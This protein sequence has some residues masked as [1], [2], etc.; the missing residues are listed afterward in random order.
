MNFENYCNSISKQSQPAS[1]TRFDHCYVYMKT[2]TRSQMYYTLIV[3]PLNWFQ[4]D[5]GV[6]YL[7]NI[8]KDFKMTAVVYTFQI[9]WILHVYTCIQSN[10][11]L[12]S[13]F[14]TVGFSH[15]HIILCKASE[16]VAIFQMIFTTI[17]DMFNTD[18]MR[19]HCTYYYP[20]FFFDA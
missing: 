6:Y 17:Y 15:E 8:L 2:N 5:F 13:D 19:A 14:P 20:F 16:R 11:F 10:T 1:V 9:L 18:G 3:Y 12:L 4:C 7:A